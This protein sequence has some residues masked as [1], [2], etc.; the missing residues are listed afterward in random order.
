[1]T[2]ASFKLVE[3]DGK[4]IPVNYTEYDVNAAHARSFTG[5][6]PYSVAEKYQVNDAQVEEELRK[7]PPAKVPPGYY[8][9]MGDN[10]NGS[11]DGRGWGLVPRNSII[12]R[13]EFIWLPLTRLGATR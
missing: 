13:S 12:G 11:F 1:M 7:A 8:L 9:M 3:R 10:R 5:E 6:A 4:V 2:K